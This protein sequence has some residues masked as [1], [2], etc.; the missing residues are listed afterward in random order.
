MF[1]L[2]N[3]KNINQLKYTVKNNDVLSNVPHNGNIYLIFQFF[4]HPDKIRMKELQ[5]CL[6]KNIELGL[7]DKII[8]L[9]EKIYTNE[10]LGITEQQSKYI[11]QINV[12]NRLKYNDIFY[13]ANKLNLNGYIVF[14]NTDIFFDETII[15]VRKSCLSKKKSFYTLSR[16]E[17]SID[18]NINEC[19]LGK[20]PHFSQDAWIYHTSQFNLNTSIL[21]DTN[22][23]FG[24]PG[25]DNKFIYVLIKNKYT[26]FNVPLNVKTY[27]YHSSDIRNYTEKERLPLPYGYVAPII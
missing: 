12:K 7:F 19:K 22:F 27:H 3:T 20:N 23:Y 11:T 10:E 16:Y 14:C 6:N 1:K 2:N 24:V 4:I 17:F 21:N 26:C 9:N 13:C 5:Y 15:N 18:K 25:C 8:L